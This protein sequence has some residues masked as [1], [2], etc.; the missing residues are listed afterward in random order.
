MAVE[1]SVLGVVVPCTWEEAWPWEGNE[2]SAAVTMLTPPMHVAA[3]ATVGDVDVWA[4]TKCVP[5][6]SLPNCRGNGLVV[7]VV[8]FVFV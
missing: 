7:V 5:A 8:V 1:Y 2:I 4:S 3:D 6:T